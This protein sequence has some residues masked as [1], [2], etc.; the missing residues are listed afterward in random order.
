MTT[1]PRQSTTDSGSHK[2][3]IIDSL[4][5]LDLPRVAFPTIGRRLSVH[6]SAKSGKGNVDLAQETQ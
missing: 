1:A 2:Y 5:R 3:L 4:E 6:L